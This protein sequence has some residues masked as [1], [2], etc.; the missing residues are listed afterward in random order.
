MSAAFR[1]FGGV[2]RGVLGDN[3]MPLVKSRDREAQ[4]VTFQ[5]AYLAF[6]EG[7]G[8]R[9][10]G[11]RAVPSADQGEG[12]VGVKYV[13][14]DA[15]EAAS[16]VGSPTARLISRHGCGSRPA[17]GCIADALL[18]ALTALSRDLMR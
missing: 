8:A 1:H 17:L 13:K 15:L 10:A 16:S 18:D 2:P 7:L 9:A 5:R 14:G 11:L 12:E 3:A 6:W 4:T